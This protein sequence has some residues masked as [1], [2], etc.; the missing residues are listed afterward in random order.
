MI[1][2]LVRRAGCGTESRF[3]A[4]NVSIAIVSDL[5]RDID[6]GATTGDLRG[7]ASRAIV[8]ASGAS[9]MSA[10]SLATDSGTGGGDA[11]G[12]KAR[13]RSDRLFPFRGTLRRVRYPI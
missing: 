5:R 4:G 1:A 7:D 3:V 12:G 8:S 9:A 2:S 10:G 11:E 6:E 13:H